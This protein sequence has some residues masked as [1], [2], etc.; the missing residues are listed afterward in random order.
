MLVECQTASVKNINCLL[1]FAKCICH[2]GAV[3]SVYMIVLLTNCA[4]F[5]CI[6]LIARLTSTKFCI[7][8]YKNICAYNIGTLHFLQ[9]HIYSDM[10]DVLYGT[11][12]M[13]NC[14]VVVSRMF[15]VKIYCDG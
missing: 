9:S 7:L 8:T 5:N 12:S 2:V 6:L 15:T 1:M 3:D 10:Y 13:Y 4:T 14:E 11:F